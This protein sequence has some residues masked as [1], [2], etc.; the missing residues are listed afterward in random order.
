[1]KQVED[2][3]DSLLPKNVDDVA[4]IIGDVYLDWALHLSLEDVERFAETHLPPA[5][6]PDNYDRYIRLG[7]KRFFMVVYFTDL[8]MWSD[9]D[10]SLR[11]SSW[12]EWRETNSSDKAKIT[13][14]INSWLKSL[15]PHIAFDAVLELILLWADRYNDNKG[16]AYAKLCG[17]N[18][19]DEYT[20]E[21]LTMFLRGCIYDEFEY[22]DMGQN[23]N[24]WKD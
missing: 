13:N 14:A 22:A 10:R 4:N 6:P 5:E 20:D 12:T 16:L 24:L 19:V 11:R 9:P 23:A 15:K 7:I 8:L 2:F 18:N 3:L 21:N 17:R 1:M